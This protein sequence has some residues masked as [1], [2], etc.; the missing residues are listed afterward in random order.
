[1]EMMMKRETKKKFVRRYFRLQDGEGP[2]EK[3]FR[4]KLSE[5]IDCSFTCRRQ[6]DTEIYTC[7]HRQTTQRF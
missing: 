2:L 6:T 1:M 4:D 5:D 7:T 3:D